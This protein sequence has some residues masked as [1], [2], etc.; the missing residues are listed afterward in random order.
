M[1]K[2]QQGNIIPQPDG[3]VLSNAEESEDEDL[4]IITPREVNVEQDHQDDQQ[5]EGPRDDQQEEGP[6][7]DQQEEGPRDDQQGRPPV[8]QLPLVRREVSKSEGSTR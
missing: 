2:D 4:Q 6:R 8:E 7:D 5:E 1:K 3:A